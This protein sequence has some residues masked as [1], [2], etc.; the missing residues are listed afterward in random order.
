[1]KRKQTIRIHDGTTL[2]YKGKAANLPFKEAAI[3][4]KSVE[5]FADDEPCVIHQS[6]VAKH[7]AEEIKALFQSTQSTTLKIRDH[8]LLNILDID[9]ETLTITLGDES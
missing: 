1:M 6:Y 5:L 8:A 2:L 4:E 7:Y 3:K 9:G